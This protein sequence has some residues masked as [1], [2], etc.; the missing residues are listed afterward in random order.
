M[1]DVIVCCVVLAG[2][3]FTAS[4]PTLKNKQ[5]HF[6]EAARTNKIK[7]PTPC[8]PHIHIHIPP[9]G[10]EGLRWKVSVPSDWLRCQ[11]LSLFE[12]PD[13]LEPLTWAGLKRKTPCRN[14]HVF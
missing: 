8:L 11:W 9:T 3:V 7:S 10:T 1:G 5:E 6:L 4:Q 12:H 13:N 2:R 14:Q